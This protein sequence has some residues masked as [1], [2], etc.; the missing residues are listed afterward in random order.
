MQNPSISDDLI[1]N[2]IIIK[3]VTDSIKKKKNYTHLNEKE[4]ID[5]AIKKSKKLIK[6]TGEK[7]FCQRID[8]LIDRYMKEIE[9]KKLL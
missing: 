5:N 8:T 3:I 6:K 7:N 9:N 2:I 4:I 1:T